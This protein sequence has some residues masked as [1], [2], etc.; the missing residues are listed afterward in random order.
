MLHRLRA[1]LTFSNTMAMTAVMIALGGTSYAAFTLPRNSVNSKNIVNGQV[2]TQ[3][4]AKHSVNATKLATNATKPTGPA[5]GDLQG[6]YPGPRLR[7]AEAWR[8]V[9]KPGQPVFENSWT[10]RPPSTIPRFAYRTVAFYKDRDG[11]VHLKGEAT[12][13]TAGKPIFALP[14]GYR[15]ATGKVIFLPVV[16][17]CAAETDSKGDTLTPSTFDLYIAGPG[18]TDQGIQDGAVVPPGLRANGG[19]SLEGISFRAGS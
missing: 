14:R 5:S 12:G 1:H 19:V 11:V 4:L 10:H 9:G 18:L 15:P 3:D 8:E 7:P 6:K 2:K 16:C 17:D 13:G